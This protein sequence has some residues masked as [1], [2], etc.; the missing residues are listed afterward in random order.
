MIKKVLFG[1]VFTL[2]AGLPAAGQSNMEQIVFD[3]ANQ[4]YLNGDY[5]SAR[6]EYQKIINSGFESVELYYNLGNTFYKLG[7]IPSAILYYEKALILDPKDVDIRFNLDLANRLVVDKINP[8][9]EFFLRKWI[10]TF[11]GIIKADAWGY[12]SLIAFIL[13]LSVVAF[14]YATRGFRFRKLMLSGGVL[15]FVILLFSLPLGSIQNA[16][17]VHPD[18]AIVFSSSL[19]AKSSP[20]SGG[21][22]LFVIHEGVKVKITDQVGSWIRIRLADGNEAWIP[23]NS[24]ERI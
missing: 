10:R 23:E 9:N 15:L 8:V 4:L 18:S 2:L 19:T 5:S 11:A 13:M 24:V 7:Q 3:K 12:I 16:Q 1:L 14:A 22:D 6:E 17:T 20:D 21:T